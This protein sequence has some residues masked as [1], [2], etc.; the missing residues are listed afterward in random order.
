PVLFGAAAAGLSLAPPR[1][2]PVLDP[3]GQRMA[4]FPPEPPRFVGRAE[5][6]AA[7]SAALAP[8]SGQ[9]GV[10][11]HGMAG[12]GKTACA[13]ELA[14][15]HQWAFAALAFWSAPT[16]P[17]Q[18]SD[19]L[20]LLA[21]ALE[22][23]L[24]DYGF[25]MVDKI[26]TLAALERF[27]PRLRALLAESG[28]LLVLDN[29]ETLLTSDGRWRDPR[30]VPL[31]GALTGHGGESRVILTSR[32]PPAGLDAGAVLVR[33]VH[34]LSRDE[35]V[36]LARELPNLR[37]L[38]HSEPEPVRGELADPALGRRVLTLVQGHPKLL[39]LADAAAADRA[40]LV[41]Q[42]AAAEA[43]VD[44]AALSAFLTQGDTALDA[45][46][47]LQ[48]LTA[49][50]TDAAATL[51]APARLLLQALCRIEDTDRDSAVLE[52]NWA[53]LWRR[54]DQP[55]EAPPLAEALTPLIT[56]AL[57]AAKPR[58][59]AE[60]DGPVGYRIHPGVAE[61]IHTATPEQV[62]TAVDTGL[63][64]WWTAIAAWGIEQER[65]GRDT[66]QVV[67]RAG[68]AAVPYL[69]RQHHWDTAG[70]FLEQAHARD[71]FS[72]ITA[73]AVLPPLRRIAG[74]TGQPNHLGRLATVLSE[75]DPAEAE[76]LLYRIYDQASTTG[77][78]RL[79]AT[80]ASHLVNLLR[81][82]GM[83][84]AALTLA[85]QKIEHTRHAG[86]GSWTQLL[87]HG[88]RLQILGL[89]GRHEQVLT[90]LPALRERMTE[91]PNQ[92][93]DNDTVVPWNVQELMLN[94]GNISAQALGRWEQAL[95]LTNEITTIQRRRGASPHDTAGTRFNDYGP[96]L[97][98]GRLAEA[99][100]L[101]RECQE[102]FDTAGDI[103]ALG[104]VYSARADLEAARGHH[105][106]AAELQR[107]ALR[108]TY[109]RPDPRTISV[110]H[111][112]L[113]D[114]LSRTRA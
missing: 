25:A 41:S 64:A 54:L 85:D 2:Q 111:H 110:S 105:R 104:A 72:P 93:A 89:L 35:S 19:A 42:L 94:T 62:S 33:P 44:G 73:Q 49:W 26:A 5:A 14:Y 95:A 102:V 91:L 27:L 39:E 8:E 34:A 70:Y 101:L 82:Q 97:R 76:T 40:R 50:T 29:L 20:R 113:A 10:L 58:D 6:L 38:L 4:G 47:F 55:G 103:T 86:L 37:T 23:Q 63:A 90:E 43:A 53:D 15:R 84:R 17:E 88:Q 31:I 114:Y 98:L 1:G 65:A 80:A 3:A 60:P 92:P 57:V 71:L 18:F 21:M 7:A 56:A 67:V 22:A 78:H 83:L 107:T 48:T 30:W 77:D 51:P 68:L 66:G 24:A 16:D 12:A 99:D 87:D 36:L 69:L 32:I 81:D 52:V 61:A 75:V 96:L 109:P 13:L 28:L 59:P 46:Q 79:A 100:Q 112:D 108:L 45:V 106:D 9:T 11:F 74:A